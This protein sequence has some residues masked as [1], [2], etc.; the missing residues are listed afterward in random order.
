MP[1][2]LRFLTNCFCI[3]IQYSPCAWLFCDRSF[4]IG[5]KRFFFRCVSFFQSIYVCTMAELQPIHTDHGH[6]KKFFATRTLP[7]LLLLTGLSVVAGYLLSKA[8]LIG[9]TGIALFYKE[10]RFFRYWWKGALAV[11]AV[12]LLLF[13]LHHFLQKQLARRQATLLHSTALAI[14]A[15]GLYFT[16]RD[17]RYDFSHRLLGERFHLGFYLF[18]IGWMLIGLFHLFQRKQALPLS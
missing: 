12:W 3:C 17:F 16:Y 2:R 10:Y 7:F 18:W 13:L 1:R 9:R 14:A 15:I 4:H 6:L 5:N 11:L 8:T